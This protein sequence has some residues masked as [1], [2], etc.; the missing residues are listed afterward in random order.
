MRCPCIVGLVALCAATAGFAAAADAS[1]YFSEGRS[2]PVGSTTQSGSAASAAVDDLNGDSRDDVVVGNRYSGNVSVLLGQGDATLA[3]AVNYASAPGSS[4][5]EVTTGDFVEDGT[6]DIAVSNGDGSVSVL[7]GNG[8][9]TFDAPVTTTIST[10]SRALAAGD[11]NGDGHEDLAV[12]TCAYP[13]FAVL[14]GKGDGTFDAPV[15]STSYGCAASLVFA[16]FDND[17]YDDLAFGE[18]NAG[19]YVFPGRAD[20]T[21]VTPAQPLPPDQ[22]LD[23]IATGYF[24]SNG[25]VDLGF[26]YRFTGVA[27]VLLGNGDGSFTAPISGRLPGGATF[28]STAVGD[29]DHDGLDDAALAVDY[30][31][32]DLHPRVAALLS[33]GDGTF[34][35][36]DSLYVAGFGNPHIAVGRFNGDVWPD[37]AVA[38]DGSNTVSLLISSAAVGFNVDDLAFDNQLTGTQSPPKTVTVYNDG[39]PPLTISGTSLVG[40][41]SADFAIQSD[42]CSGK[43]LDSDAS[44]SLSLVFTPTS[45]VAS[46]ASL[47]ITSDS[48]EGPDDLPLK[49]QG[50]TGPP[51]PPALPPPIKPAVAT[52]PVKCI[53]P[54]L[55]GITVKK[56]KRLLKRRHCAVGKITRK[57]STRRWH[58]RVIATKPHRGARRPARTRVALTVGR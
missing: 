48:P 15:T 12:A 4:P 26:A 3:D 57:R 58:G 39:A 50:A 38:H 56:A 37:I 7:A 23:R 10:E 20:G 54:K 52:T 44:C 25:T 55:K 9:G 34:V 6:P 18:P 29:L 11:M 2:Y 49:G 30:T 24:D 42:S 43:V 53:V 5:R 19:I 27:G 47:R 40:T 22:I 32:S 46:T 21:L 51:P 14:L 35:L 45:A 41:N 13:S 17:G 1:V 16:D 33:R 31:I 36:G 28:G 8:D